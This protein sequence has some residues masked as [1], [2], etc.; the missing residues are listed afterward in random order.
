[1]LKLLEKLQKSADFWFV[2]GTSLIF[3]L[4]RFPSFFEP[5]WY[6]DE[7]IYEVIGFALRHGRLL[8]RD[9]WDNKPPILYLIYAIGSGDQMVAKILS[10]V[11]GLFAIIVFFFLAKKLFVRKTSIW[12]ATGLFALF[13]GLPVLEGNI[14]NA[15]NFMIL[16]AVVGA[17][18][19]VR[20][21]AK[22]HLLTLSLAGFILGISFL[23]KV[24]AIFDVAACWTF[25]FL[26]TF[27]SNSFSK[28][29]KQTLIY[30]LAFVGS[31]F[32]P[33]FLTIVYF[34]S[35]GA[36]KIFLQSAFFS[37][38]GYVNY[39]NQFVIPQGFLIFK[40][41]L[42][43]I[44]L[45]FLFWRRK[46]FSPSQLFIFIWLGFSLFNAFFSQRPYTHYLLVL[47]PSFCLFV[48]LLFEKQS[49]F[50]RSVFLVGIL[51]L[52]VLLSKNFWF[53]SKTFSY[54]RN[55]VNYDTG[56]ENLFTYQTF[57][58]KVVPRDYA[59]AD[60]LSLHS[61]V[62]DHVFV[63]G[64]SGQIYKLSHTLPPGRYIVAYHI[65]T[66]AQTLL[67]TSAVLQKYPPKFVILLPNGPSFPFTL[68]N[69]QQLF[70]IDG[71]IIY[72][73]PF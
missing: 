62:S 68:S 49:L 69:Y 53:Y 31:F 5:Y 26:L 56:K 17:Y 50:L 65:T 45:L 63:W 29:L 67:E 47:L 40:L 71:G 42:L 27:Q 43:S 72:E 25:L 54:Y 36:L 23:I 18:L 15:E 16:P 59:L 64:N 34:T 61:S 22:K 51:G 6:G 20:L 46:S 24:V 73:R 60:F 14:A 8:Y 12:I 55:F 48:S 41:L 58:D 3:F 10:F 57:F 4:L 35:Q 66:N 7:G 70:T 37:N 52:A 13:L 11:A 30:S 19:I 28:L 21:G 9:I 33:L 32:I 38:V 39:G 1:M 2:L 44:F